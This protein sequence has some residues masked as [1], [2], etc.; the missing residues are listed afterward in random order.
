[1]SVIF[2]LFLLVGFMVVGV[3]GADAASLYVDP[4]YS[5][6]FRGDEIKLG[7]RLD[8][9]EQ[10]EECV[11]AIDA[12]ITYTDNIQPVDVSIGDSIFSMWVEQPV[13]NKEQR[14]ITFAGGIP[15][16]YCGRVPGDP[17]LTNNIVE[18]IFRS[19]GFMVGSP[20]DLN[21]AVIEFGPET[22]AYL[23]DGQGTKADLAT[24]GAQIELDKS[25]GSVMQDPWRTEVADDNILPQ[26]FSITLQKDTRAFSAKYFIVFNTT[27]KETGIDHYEI[28]EEPLSEIGAF[29]WGRTDAPW[30]TSRSPYVLKDQTLNSV[31]RVK[32]VDKAGNE[33]I[34]TL[35]PNEDQ[36]AIPTGYFIIA[37]GLL[38]IL[39]MLVGIGITAWRTRKRKEFH[40]QIAAE[41][42]DEI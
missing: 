25:A 36:R 5:T 32:A 13:I 21:A 20:S 8:V 33:Y 24:Y 6:I 1:M 23:N 14:T 10:A 42:T 16:G 15:N 4:A 39:L 30:I 2:R 11:N 7:V 17:R 34:A 31:I 35:I 9:D 40:K 19:P 29:R 26:E 37:A 41:V 18:L 28:I 22:T 38:I 12:V 27:D 3:H